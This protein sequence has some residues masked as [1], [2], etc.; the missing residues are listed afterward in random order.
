M[1]L[2]PSHLLGITLALIAAFAALHICTRDRSGDTAGEPERRFRNL[3]AT[4]TNEMS[5]TSDLAGLDRQ[6]KNFMSRWNL[7]GASLS[8]MRNDSLVYSKGYGWA[9]E[10]AGVEM[11]P[12]IIL[13]IASVSKLV[14]AVGIMTLCERGSLSLDSKVFGPDGILCDSLYTA[15]IRDK[16][17]Y[18]IT[19][20]H[21][22]RHQ[23]GFKAGSFDPLFST[24][25]L[26][27]QNRWDTPPD[28]RQLLTSQLSKRL[29]FA[30][31]TS[32]S[33]SNLGYLILSM[34]I[35]K[36][37]G[38]PYETWMQENV[39]RRSG[40]RD[41]HIARNYYAEK[42]PNETRYHMQEN[43]PS[44][45]EY[46]NSGRLVERCYGGNDIRALSGAGAWVA[47]SAELALLVAS[48]DGRGQ[49]P[50]ILTAES[51]R[52]MTEYFDENTYALGW[53]DTKPTGEW[54]RTGTLS[55]TT[56]LI[57]YYP[58][59]E[60][61]IFISNTGTWVGPRLSSSTAELF[62]KC[63]EKYSQKLPHRDFFSPDD[64]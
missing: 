30:P 9:D 62:R 26:M 39:L 46:N 18:S 21:L 17:Y 12:G 31:G 59:G 57:K 3:N 5:D 38:E 50:D 6:V 27:R 42:Y 45:D 34:V 19:I 23:G 36:V 64:V 2:R 24:R 63:R 49:V 56:A 47:S 16:N 22:L 52:K 44:V 11:G 29:S 14:T 51:V 4:L 53:N 43:D 41:F 35:E 8:I 20:E 54:T 55:G 37:T 7:Q 58:D 32:Q 10:K 25:A 28:A 1:K 15:R 40:C 48:I 13:R 33:Y 60:C 61:W